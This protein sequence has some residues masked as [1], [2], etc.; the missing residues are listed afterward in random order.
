L[1][2]LPDAMTSCPN[3]LPLL[4]CTAKIPDQWGIEP[5]VDVSRETSTTRGEH[6]RTLY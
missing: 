1:K 3:E 6:G 2:L 4:R 5:F